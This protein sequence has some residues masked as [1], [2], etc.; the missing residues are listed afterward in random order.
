MKL[1]ALIALLLATGTEAAAQYVLAATGGAGAG[2]DLYVAW[3]I[4]EQVIAAGA[5]PTVGATQGFH[6]PPQ[7][8]STSMVLSRG[9]DTEWE[10]FPNPTRGTLQL[11]TSSAHARHAEVI[12]ALGQRLRTWSIDAMGSSWSVADLASGSYRLQVYDSANNPLHTLTFI[13]AQ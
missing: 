8:F 7:D 11:I 4:G 13:V 6:Q 5:G 9:S 3:T 12:N 2:A 10:L 1:L